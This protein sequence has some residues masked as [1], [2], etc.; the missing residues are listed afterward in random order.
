MKTLNRN[1]FNEK[2]IHRYLF[3]RLYFGDKKIIKSLLPEK[4]HKNKINLIAP[5]ESKGGYRAD[6]IIY[7]KDIQAGVPVEVKWN[8]N[9]SLGTNQ[10]EYLSKNNGI[11]I[12]FEKINASTFKGIDYVSIDHEDFSMWVAENISKLSRECLLYQAQVKAA[13]NGNQMWVVYLRGTAHENWDR[14]LTS[15]IKKPFWAFK[16]NSKALKNILDIQ[17]DDMCL[18]IKGYAKEGIG[19]SNNPKLKLEYSGWY[20]TQVKEPYY[21]ALDEEKGTFFEADN[22]SVNDR[23]WPHFINFEIKDSFDT[24]EFGGKK[25]VFGNKGELSGVLADSVNY[26]GGTP[27]PINNLR[28]ES[29]IDKLKNQK[30]QTITK[31]NNGKSKSKTISKRLK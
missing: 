31:Y 9:S 20:L 8:T 28:W 1:A 24:N 7:F 15:F 5:E 23:K 10:L 26:G 27:A 18:F 13:T 21:M 11:L 12:S 17:K 22:P 29:L 25:I 14:M 16:Q 30:I 4:Y 3:E 19:M 2:L 6:L